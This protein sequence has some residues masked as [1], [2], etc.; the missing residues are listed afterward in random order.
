MISDKQK[1]LIISLFLI[2][3]ASVYILGAQAKRDFWLAILLSIPLTMIMVFI[4]TRLHYIFPRKNLFEMIETLFGK[5]IGKIIIFLFVLY[6]FEYVSQELVYFTQYLKNVDLVDTPNIFI[7]ISGAIVCFWMVKEGLGVIGGFAQLFCP[8]IIIIT[9]STILLLIPQM[10]PQNLSPFLYDGI[11]P[12]LK[13]AYLVF[14]YPFGDMIVFTMLFSFYNRRSSYSTY[15]SG[16]IIAVIVLM[17]I[18]LTN[19]MVLGIETGLSVYFPSHLTV[20]RLNVNAIFQRVEVITAI[21]FMIGGVIKGG[22]ML[23]CTSIGIAKIFEYADYRLLLIP[24]TLL[25]INLSYFEFGSSM[26]AYEFY[27]E[28]Y[29]FY[30]IIFQAI[31]PVIIWITAEVKKNHLNPK[32][33]K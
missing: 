11:G 24:I 9:F 16:V 6:T 23:L 5:F 14:E 19:V 32:L 30:V 1:V 28:I 4:Y 29:P 7:A 27:F 10:N 17:A 12:V 22:I 3:E 21:V 26:E 25:A 15:I 20:S 2:G 13:G 33:H 18:S 31:L 8:F